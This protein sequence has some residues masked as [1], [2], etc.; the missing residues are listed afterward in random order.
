MTMVV[1][2]G[3]VLWKEA[4]V[5]CGVHEV[6]RR[7]YNAEMAVRL[8]RERREVGQRYKEQRQRSHVDAKVDRRVTCPVDLVPGCGEVYLK[9]M[10]LSVLVLR[11]QRHSIDDSPRNLYAI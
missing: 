6:G 2:V 10:V 5:N 9:G 4:D 7:L 11:P 1:Q 3:R 8:W